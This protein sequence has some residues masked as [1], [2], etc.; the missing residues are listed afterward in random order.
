M[1][2]SVHLHNFTQVGIYPCTVSELC[3]VHEDISVHLQ[4]LTIT[5]EE[6]W[7]A[8]Y[9]LLVLLEPV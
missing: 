9:N 4:V 7:Q 1:D 2:I 3:T 5:K 6:R 8:A